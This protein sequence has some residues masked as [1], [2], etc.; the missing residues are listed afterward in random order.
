NYFWAPDPAI[1]LHRNVVVG[2]VPWFR[3][4]GWFPRTDA[5]QEWIKRQWTGWQ[6][7]GAT[8]Y[9]RPNWFLDGYAMPRFS[10]HQFADA[11]QFYARHGMTGTDFDS[12]QGQWAAQGPNLYLLARL[13]VRPEAPADDLLG[14]YYRA[15]GPAADTIKEYWDYWEGYAIKNRPRA[16]ESIR[17]RRGGNFRRYALYAQ[18]ADELYPAGC[19]GPAKAILSRALE[20]TSSNDAALYRRRVMFLQDG[21]R[22]AE[23][24]SATA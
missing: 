24:C 8:L 22:H 23:Q 13:H 17:S 1:K 10:M 9:Y 15:F 3:A 7:S 12:L 20:K 11:F 16:F 4:A 21:L 2:F 19:F 6:G 5:E 18:V 14:E